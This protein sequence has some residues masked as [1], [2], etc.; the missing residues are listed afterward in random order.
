MS[1]SVVETDVASVVVEAVVDASL[2]TDP[3]DA[4]AAAAGVNR[5]PDEILEVVDDDDDDDILERENANVLEVLVA[6][7]T[8]DMKVDMV[9]FIIGICTV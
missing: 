3:R 5:N 9:N 1:S 2:T 4:P 6:R 7:A 8:T